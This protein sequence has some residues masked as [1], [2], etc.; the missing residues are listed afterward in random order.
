MALYRLLKAEWPDLIC[1]KCA[2]KAISLLPA[3]PSALRH[4]FSSVVSG[5]TLFL[6]TKPWRQTCETQRL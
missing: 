5:V 4:V 2:A 1:F 6:P 3:L